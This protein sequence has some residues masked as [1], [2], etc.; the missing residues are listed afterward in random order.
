MC[1][2]PVIRWA[3]SPRG[4]Y[5]RLRIG[6]VEL[7]ERTRE[8]RGPGGLLAAQPKVF[9]LLVYLVRERDRVVSREDILRSIWPD[10]V[11]GPDS[12]TRALRE[13]RRLL[14]RADMVR[15]Y[16]GR[17]VRFV[18]AVSGDAITNE[19]ELVGIETTVGSIDCVLARAAARRGGLLI[20]LGPPG[21]GKSSVVALAAERARAAGL[22]TVVHDLSRATRNVD[23]SDVVA[24]AAT[25]V[26]VIAECCSSMR[27]DPRVTAVLA[28]A[29]RLD[30]DAIVT[31]GVLRKSALATLAERVL[32][33][34][35]SPAALAKLE[36]LTGGNPRFARHVL[37]MA[38]QARRALETLDTLPPSFADRLRDLVLDHVNV[39]G[40]HTRTLLD[41]IS[42]LDRP[43]TFAIAAEVAG[44]G[45]CESADALANA[46]EVGLVVE[47]SPGRWRFAHE[48]V[49]S[50]VE[51]ELVPSRRATYHARAAVALEHVFGTPFA[52]LESIARHY[53]A[54][55][56]VA[57]AARALELARQ[58]AKLAIEAHSFGVAA[59]WFATAVDLEAVLEPAS[60]QRRRALWLELA[61]VLAR[62]GQFERA[63]EAFV[64]AESLAASARGEGDAVRAAFHAIAA[65]L[66]QIVERF[67]ELLFSRHP[68]LS[69]M[70]G[71]STGLQRRMFGE[72]IVAYV[73][74]ADDPDWLQDHLEA[75]GRR[76]AEYGVTEE[77]Y[78]WARSAFLDAMALAFA[79]KRLAIDVRLTWERTFDSIART[80]IAAGAAIIGGM[81]AL[82]SPENPRPSSH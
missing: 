16:P 51:R 36:A 31:L 13:V 22:A 82:A 33:R 17:G 27:R 15:T 66:P 28:T 46:A 35:V 73:D 81:H 59:R 2:L 61:K 1:D 38:K 62:D 53:V 68:Q 54:G 48:L 57:H 5:V 65:A 11:V 74:H 21:S 26:L 42:I 76:H 41:A 30:P 34:A 71:R 64:V 47:A 12:I 3:V 14:G 29:S 25:P 18:G 69:P 72:A 77:M 56:S 44:I 58:A 7:D 39:V 49:R 19:N 52:H 20:V 45:R 23:A 43:V 60:P 50:V 78:A 10:T 40:A 70:F 75:L 63:G 79:P 4:G 67:Y 32:G 9:D 80:M 37:H 24:M 6:E 55:A 8:L